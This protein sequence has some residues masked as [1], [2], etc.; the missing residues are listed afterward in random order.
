VTELQAQL[1]EFRAHYNERR[2][3]RALHRRTPGDAYRATP[4]AL[5]ATNGHTPGHYRL[6]YDR[7]D[8][9]GKMSIRRAGRMHHL[10]IGTVHA[11]KRVLA[12]AD[13]HHITVAELTTGEV[14]ST[15]LIEP[16]KTYWR[17]QMREPGRWPDPQN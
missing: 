16:N 3:H 8:T 7:L 6:R 10:G 5:P 14:L 12:F 17:N 15:H 9:K 2:P 1:N 11:R 13:D 4:K